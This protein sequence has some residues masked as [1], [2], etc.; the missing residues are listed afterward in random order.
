MNKILPY[1]TLTVLLFAC[2][3]SEP[4]L[5]IE[6]ATEE[7]EVITEQPEPEPEP[8]IE[9]EPEPESE[10]VE[11][12][13]PELDPT[14]QER[15]DNLAR[16]PGE[17][18][19][20]R[21]YDFGAACNNASVDERLPPSAWFE[22]FLDTQDKV[23]EHATIVFNNNYYEA[24]E[25]LEA[26]GSHV[27]FWEFWC[28]PSGDDWR[29]AHTILIVGLWLMEDA[30]FFIDQYNQTGD[31]EYES[32]A[33]QAYNEGFRYINQGI[34]DSLP[35]YGDTPE[36]GWDNT[37]NVECIRRGFTSIAT[38]LCED[39][40]GPYLNPDHFAYDPN[41][42]TAHEM[43]LDNERRREEMIELYGAEH[44]GTYRLN[45]QGCRS[46]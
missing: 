38:P 25:A 40:V 42:M 9:E 26:I 46:G 32:R 3:N 10:V 35:W 43:C 11:E 36:F 22:E 18:W 8:I 27:D 34:R 24:P 41:A 1:L 13:E 15:E 33:I 16:L 7:P 19:R 37:Y 4:E 20:T 29:D 21:T 14:A 6:S 39:Y 17:S 31:S 2:A 12:P 28:P 45:E 23:V 30:H 5:E 44:V